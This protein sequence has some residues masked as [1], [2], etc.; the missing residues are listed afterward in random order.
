L[1]GLIVGLV[2]L[3]SLAAPALAAPVIDLLFVPSPDS[4]L[5]WI[6]GVVEGA[7]PSDWAVVVYI[8]VDGS[9][10]GPKPTWTEPLTPI[11]ADG[12]WNATFVTGGNDR[13]ADRFAVYL[14][15]RGALGEGMPPSLS[16]AA[17]LPSVLAGYARD[18]SS[19]STPELRT[20]PPILR[21]GTDLTGLCVGPYLNGEQP[22]Q[23]LSE[24][25]LRERLAVVADH[26]AWIRS[27]GVDG[28][29]ERF[30]RIAHDLGRRAAVGAWLSK[31]PVQNRRALEE[32][33]SIGKNGD[34][35]LLIVGSESLLRG[36]V[37]ERD[38]V[39]YLRWVR[40]EVPGMPVGTA[41]A[42]TVF[43]DHPSLVEASDLL[44]VHIYPF[45]DGVGIGDA[46]NRTVGAWEGVAGIAKD[47]PVVIAETGW[48]DAG[49][50]SGSA[51]PSSTNATRYLNETT[52]LLHARGIPYFYF[53]AFDEEWKSE[54][55]GVG[56]HWGIWDGNLGLKT[57]RLPLPGAV[58]PFPGGTALPKDA[59][60]DGL[61]EDVNG[62]RRNDF[63]DVT[64]YFGRMSWIPTNEPLAAFD[65]NANGRIDF[66]DVVT[67]F[68]SL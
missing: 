39:T 28:G 25:V 7:T 54:P 48:P 55:G 44:M 59:N 18:E 17:S 57:G 34:A 27:Y 64:L 8:R 2:L 65:Y 29:L 47:R 16:G 61:F 9:W 46:A 10:W 26:A 33:A 68:R 51:V 53:A 37:S 4:S 38:L 35:D 21:N 67:L 30:G 15:P 19:R 5:D 50:P 31:D 36:D 22:G 63:A 3:P 12:F 40:R 43:L 62:N 23:L 49:D 66:A 6:S 13:T 56:P 1:Y 58:V 60:G 45:W 14:I 41:D 52:A 11:R 24:A 20:V 42:Y 32:L